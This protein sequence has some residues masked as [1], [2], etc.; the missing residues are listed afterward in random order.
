ML[1]AL[2]GGRA[3]AETDSGVCKQR[4]NREQHK[5]EHG[6]EP[7]PAE[8]GDDDGGGE[9][10]PERGKLEHAARQ[11]AQHRADAWDD[12]GGDGEW[13]DEENEAEVEEEEADEADGPHTRV[14]AI[15]EC[16]E[17]VVLGH[18]ALLQL[19]D[20]RVEPH[21]LGAHARLPR[22][23]PHVH[24]DRRQH[25][26]A[27][28]AVGRPAHAHVADARVAVAR[29][30]RRVEALAPRVARVQSDDREPRRRARRRRQR[31]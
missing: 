7:E 18:V 27:R 10:D 30:T 24:V 26:G 23:H 9:R 8:A 15:L 17:E 29:P 20:R 31:R 22:D 19:I 16:L 3:A 1:R 4:G 28:R 12:V 11:V 6:A 5:S 25:A 13:L 2:G 14:E 21:H